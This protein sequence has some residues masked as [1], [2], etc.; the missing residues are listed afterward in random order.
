MADN[1]E[2][3][4]AYVTIIPSM[5][6]AQATISNELG[7]AAESA[8]DDAGKKA[9]KSL[10]DGIGKSLSNAGSALT[11]SVTA[12]ILA[13]GTASV[14]AWKQVD[15]GLD[16]IATKTGATGEQLDGMRQILES[17]TTSIPV[18]F[19]EAGTAI[20]EVNTRFG[21]TGQELE[22]L[23]T[24]FL[25]F[26][27]INSVDVNS[28]VDAVSKALAAFGMDASSA[29]SMLDALNVVG[30]Q[31]GVNVTTLA[32][33]LAQ[34]AAAFQQMGISAY[35]AAAFLGQADMAGIEATTMLTGLKKAMQNATA[36]GI[37]LDQAIAQFS[38]TMQ[39]NGSET[40]K[41]AAA[42]ELFGTK[43]GAAIYNAVTSGKLNIED[44][45]GSLTDFGGSVQ[46]TFN[47]TVD[48]MDRLQAVLNEL[49]LLGASLVEAAAP[50]IHEIAD[51][52]IPIIH[53]L[54]E[55]WNSLDPGMQE[56]IIKAAIVAAA[57]G[58]MISTVSSI[59]S[60]ISG[61]IGVLG[62][63]SPV[64]LIVVGAIAGIIAIVQNWGAISEWL[65]G[66]WKTVVAAVSAAAK[67][68]GNTI[69]QIW[70][71]I[72]TVTTTVWNTV[73]SFVTT[74]WNT[75]K[76]TA[77][78]VWESIKSMISSV[79]EAVKSTV[80]G[81]VDSVKTA[82]SNAWEAIKGWTSS[83]W[84]TVKSS[85]LNVWEAIKNAFSNAWETMTNI[86]KNIVQGIWNGI[87]GAFSW[88]K[89]KI[90]GWV[91]DVLGFFKRILGIASPSKVFE[92]DIGQNIGL[93]IGK[94]IEDT[95]P[96][97]EESMRSM[98]SGIMPDVNVSGS[99]TG[100]GLGGGIVMN[101]YGAA[102]QDV[103][104]LADIVMDRLQ[105]AVDREEAAFA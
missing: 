58:P 72:K 17:I 57:I 67:A 92:A 83:A 103:N 98:M 24:L 52:A 104:A 35:D 41:L 62:G 53:Q 28:S 51:V 95:I 96:D 48:P 39:G 22:Q 82:I 55:A 13:I 65:S 49:M 16:T 73:K 29:G 33:L 38:A 102:G 56:F 42:Y 3:A 101:V 63:F 90:E 25:Q 30:Q 40:D 80:T 69:S 78:S 97:V 46:E 31:T 26:A 32:T 68:L 14:A 86:G 12:P 18:G 34:N 43:A 88:I 94:G 61:L 11:K 19:A 89:N 15:E 70:N 64:A 79:W 21:V 59:A 27:H 100:A 105:M 1:I 85:V 4:R 23:S 20:G 44:L 36:D 76:S 93:G 71:T 47:A 77:T 37:T 2:V 84:E 75:I 74:T 87:S 5:Q 10:T 6:G 99:A 9:G 54:V 50:I 45:K 81:A 60:G 7:A 66:V 91:G 8:G